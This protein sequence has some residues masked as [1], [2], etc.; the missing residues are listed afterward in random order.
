MQIYDD[1]S[2]IALLFSTLLHLVLAYLFFFGLPTKSYQTPEAQ[3]VIFEMLPVGDISN[4]K[5]KKQTLISDNKDEEG[6]KTV[7]NKALEEIE[8]KP[9]EQQKLLDPEPVKTEPEKPK[10]EE[11]IPGEVI[12]EKVSKE[13]P[14]P[15][16]KL[17]EKIQQKKEPEKK[18]EPKNEMPKPKPKDK[19]K[20]SVDLDS[21][22]KNLEKSSAGDKAKSAKQVAAEKKDDENSSG[23]FDEELPLSVTEAN[24]IHNKIWKNWRPPLGGQNADKI[25]VTYKIDFNPDGSVQKVVLESEDCAGVAANLCNAFVQSAERAIWKASPIENLRSERYN[26]WKNLNFTFDPSTLLR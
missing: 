21:L 5:E 1:N 2:F 10:V 9:V 4:I 26:V 19:K 16:D 6:K 12:P 11:E 22:L 7:Q 24:I 25:R 14:K 18:I 20:P 15:I 17:E 13:Q 23:D 8:K 3:V